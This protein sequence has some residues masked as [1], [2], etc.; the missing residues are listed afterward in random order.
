MVTKVARKPS[1][2]RFYEQALTKAEQSQLGEALDVAGIDE[3]IAALRLRLRKAI[4]ESPED[5]PLI[6][7]GMDVMR[8]MVATKYGLSR[9]DQRGLE[10]AFAQ[11]TLR[12]IEERGE[13]GEP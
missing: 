2:H 4:S 11:E 5:M 1:K 13:G 3:E 6:L 7:R 9:E 10:F 12:R 8:R